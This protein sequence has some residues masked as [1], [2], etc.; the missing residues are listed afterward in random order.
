MDIILVLLI[1]VISLLTIISISWI[2]EKNRFERLTY[3]NK[4]LAADIKLLESIKIGLKSNRLKLAE[5]LNDNNLEILEL[6]RKFIRLKI[7]YAQ[8]YELH[9]G[10]EYDD[11]FVLKFDKYGKHIDEYE[12]IIKDI[13][14]ES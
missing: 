13:K 14:S 2:K 1:V 9:Y 6:Q 10:Y 5:K 8:L 4:S 7:D 12:D 11:K 3:V